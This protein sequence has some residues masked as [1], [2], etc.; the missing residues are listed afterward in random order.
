MDEARQTLDLSAFKHVV[1][2]IGVVIGLGVARIV[3]SMSQYIQQRERVRFSAIHAIWTT[4]LF[5]MFVGVW[6][7][8][9]G[10]RNVEAE[11]W[12]FFTLIY[13]LAGPA[14]IYLPSILLLPE[15]PDAGE[16]DL[17]SLFDRMGRPIFLCLVGFVLWLACTGLYLLRE[18]FLAPQRA[19]QGVCVGAWL[20][21]AVFPSRRMAAGVGALTLVTVI[22][23]L[24]TVRA[25]L[26]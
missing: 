2:P 22:L 8:F 24:A 10:L 26:A 9:W 14:L 17:G 13:L 6:W 18:P 12:T 5:L 1:V 25:N 11:R 4:Q 23:T 16:L 19:V 21:G 7:I 15:V 3:I 20:I